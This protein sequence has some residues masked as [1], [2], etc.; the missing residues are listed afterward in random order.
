VAAHRRPPTFEPDPFSVA[1]K[2]TDASNIEE[3]PEVFACDS[4]SSRGEVKRSL[5]CVPTVPGDSQNPYISSK[6]LAAC[7]SKSE[8]CTE[9]LN[10]LRTA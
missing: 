7:L 6:A 4:F 10:D 8:V 1:A 9:H 5:D 3:D 2:Q